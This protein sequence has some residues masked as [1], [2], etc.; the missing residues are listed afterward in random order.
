MM[1]HYEMTKED[2]IIYADQGVLGVTMI[3]PHVELPDG[4]T[5]M[6][7]IRVVTP[8]FFKQ[9]Y[10]SHRLR[11]ISREEFEVKYQEAS[12]GIRSYD[13]KQWAAYLAETEKVPVSISG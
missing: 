11:A 3:R 13:S 10:D 1:I 2:S 8:E 9:Y 6:P 4:T 7:S 12:E 5:Q